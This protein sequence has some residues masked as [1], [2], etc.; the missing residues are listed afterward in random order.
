MV[1]CV[2]E[3]AS[4]T[5][6][7]GEAE[8]AGSLRIFVIFDPSAAKAKRLGCSGWLTSHE[9]RALFTRCPNGP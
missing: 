1:G 6:S 7:N 2:I 8:A 3:K 9:M 4:S 5:R